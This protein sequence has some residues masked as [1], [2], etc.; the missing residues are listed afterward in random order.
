MDHCIVSISEATELLNRKRLIELATV[1]NAKNA[2]ANLTGMLL[3]SGGNFFQV[4][5][6]KERTLDI[7]YNK[8]LIDPRHT[9]IE[10][11]MYCPIRER[12]FRKWHMGALDLT[13]K[14][15]CDRDQFRFITDQASCD[16][17]A[18]SR[19]A[20][21]VLKMFRKALPDPNMSD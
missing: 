21:T 20:M 12:T 13:G 8:I 15:P 18:A 4:L 7:L 2:P 11:L 16:P 6:G 10:R 19:A 5:E 3:Y 14:K 9:K 1:S 17:A